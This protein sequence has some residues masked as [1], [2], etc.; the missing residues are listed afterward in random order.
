MEVYNG[1]PS[2]CPSISLSVKTIIF[3]LLVLQRNF[4]KLH[5]LNL[6]KLLCSICH[7]SSQPQS[8]KMDQA[9]TLQACRIAVERYRDIWYQDTTTDPDHFWQKSN[10]MD[11]YLR[12]AALAT[13]VFGDPQYWYQVLDTTHNGQTTMLVDYWNCTTKAMNGDGVWTDDFGWGGIACL[14]LAE[15][16]KVN[17]PNSNPPWTAWRDLGIDCFDHMVKYWDASTD[18]IPVQHGISNRPPNGESSDYA[19]NTVTNANFMAL[20]MHLYHFLKKYSDN[21]HPGKLKESIQYAYNQYL[22]FLGWINTLSNGTWIPYNYFHELT[23]APPAQPS[24]AMLEERPVAWPPGTYPVTVHPPFTPSSSWSGDQGLFLNACSLLLTHS[25][26][27]SLIPLA[28]GEITVVRENLTKWMKFIS[29]GVYLALTSNTTDNVLRESPFGNLFNGDPND[30][31]CGRGVF[32]RFINEEETRDAFNSI[33]QP[34]SMFN[35]C[36]RDTAKCIYEGRDTDDPDNKVNQ[37]SARWNPQN[38]RAAY[39][40]FVEVWRCGDPSLS[41]KVAPLDSDVGPIWRNYCMMMGFDV[42]GAWLR[43]SPWWTLATQGETNGIEEKN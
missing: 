28:P 38:D 7:F 23:A 40:H 43:T 33:S 24:A 13:K 39:L 32:S 17:R 37:L 41:W 35:N 5:H 21:S 2:P 19:K 10:Q 22:W 20:S 30:Y 12:F 31:M 27:L 29:N 3:P 15:Y 14:T 26:D 9:T 16:L 18:A 42:Y 11:S 6:S 25:E 4:P 1:I 8:F 34:L 36:F